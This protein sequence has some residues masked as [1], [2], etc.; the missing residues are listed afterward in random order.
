MAEKGQLGTKCLGIL[1]P[2]N[3]FLKSFSVL[4]AP[5]WPTKGK[6]M[7][8]SVMVVTAKPKGEGR[9]HD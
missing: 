1:S 2:G 3:L 8:S 4:S 6:N 9:G 5:F 7:E